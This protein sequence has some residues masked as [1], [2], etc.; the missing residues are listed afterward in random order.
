MHTFL[1]DELRQGMVRAGQARQGKVVQRLGPEF[2]YERAVNKA[3]WARYNLTTHTHTRTHSHTFM[4][5]FGSECQIEAAS[6]AFYIL[7]YARC[8]AVLWLMKLQ[9]TLCVRHIVEQVW[10]AIYSY[11]VCMTPPWYTIIKSISFHWDDDLFISHFQLWYLCELSSKL[12]KY[13]LHFHHSPPPFAL[14]HEIRNSPDNWNLWEHTLI[15][16]T[17]SLARAHLS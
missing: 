16:S 2:V 13:L 15:L 9:S 6:Y 11:I 5:V 14:S 10:Q 7:A 1:R 4:R 3:N 17:H 8:A 12:K